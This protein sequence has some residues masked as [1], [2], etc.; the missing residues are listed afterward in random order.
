MARHGHRHLP[1]Q[2]CQGLNPA[3]VSR[4][5]M[6]ISEVFTGLGEAAGEVDCYAPE[7]EKHVSIL[8]TGQK[9]KQEGN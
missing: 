3:G 8:I 6:A 9:N 2:G 7:T 4:S 5:L 1:P